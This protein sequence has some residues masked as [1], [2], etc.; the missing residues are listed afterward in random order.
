MFNNEKADTKGGSLL[1]VKGAAVGLGLV[2][3]VR[4]PTLIQPVTVGP[5]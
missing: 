5:S 4:L 2:F 1:P 3:Q